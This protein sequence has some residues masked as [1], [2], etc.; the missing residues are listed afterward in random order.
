MVDVIIE[1]RD[2]V[3]RFGPQVIHDHL[4]LD[5]YK[6]EIIGIVGGSGAGKTVLLN[7]I[8]G[9]NKAASGT[10]RVFHRDLSYFEASVKLQSRWGVLYQ[11]GALFSSLTVEENLEVPMLEVAEMP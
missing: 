9:L 4:D 6:G 3:T 11:H 5:V 10:I 7:T 1:I 8:I 2:L